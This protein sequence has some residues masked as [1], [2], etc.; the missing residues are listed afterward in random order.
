[1]NPGTILI[2]VV[3]VIGLV[4][5]ATYSLK[6]TVK[7]HFAV[8]DEEQLSNKALEAMKNLNTSASSLDSIFK[9]P[10]LSMTAPDSSNLSDL[11]KTTLPD[12]TNQRAPPKSVLSM[13]SQQPPKTASSISSQQP[14]PPKTALP[15]IAPPPPAPIESTN[16]I[17]DEQ[18]VELKRPQKSSRVEPSNPTVK[19]LAPKIIY[20]TKKVYVKSKCPPQPDLSEYV[21]KDSIPCY[22][23]NLQ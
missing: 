8:V 2:I 1:M 14:V 19:T 22:G 18:G 15:M 10:D 17:S 21:K 11:F 16:T 3:G 4:L 23:C 20:K 9:T 5:Y 12:T 6:R 13:S 7:E